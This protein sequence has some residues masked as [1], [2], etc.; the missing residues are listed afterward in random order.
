MDCTNYITK[1]VFDFNTDHDIL[2]FRHFM[3]SDRSSV[4]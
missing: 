1:S 4:V 3:I 2:T